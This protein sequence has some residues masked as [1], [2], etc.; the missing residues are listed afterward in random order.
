MRGRSCDQ[1]K[2]A[3]LR[4]RLFVLR[5]LYVSPCWRALC[6]ECKQRVLVGLKNEGQELGFVNVRLAEQRC[7]Q[8]GG[9]AAML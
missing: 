5:W 1:H 3:L 6:E 8:V 9:L 4:F 7:P 2:N